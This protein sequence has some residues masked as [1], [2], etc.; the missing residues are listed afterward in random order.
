MSTS[1]VRVIEYVVRTPVVTYG[2]PSS[3]IEY[4]ASAPVVFHATPA[5]LIEKKKIR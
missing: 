3:V 1:P 4:V 5:T 2:A